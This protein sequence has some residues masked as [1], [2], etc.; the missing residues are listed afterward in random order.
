MLGTPGHCWMQA[1]SGAPGWQWSTSQRAQRELLL[2]RVSRATVKPGF[3]VLA[4]P[5]HTL[6]EKA[7][8]NMGSP[9]KPGWREEAHLGRGG[10]GCDFICSTPKSSANTGTLPKPLL[11]QNRQFCNSHRAAATWQSG[12]PRDASTREGCQHHRETSTPRRDISTTVCLFQVDG[13]S[14]SQKPSLELPQLTGKSQQAP[15][16]FFQAQGAAKGSAAQHGA[17]VLPHWGSW[18]SPLHWTCLWDAEPSTLGCCAQHSTS[19]AGGTEWGWGL[20]G[21]RW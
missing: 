21:T 18:A 7:R 9:E 17:P 4:L 5:L 2:P 16:T 3:E 15:L 10:D 12:C 20:P 19:L 13:S 14:L 1:G 8:S 6:P 11:P